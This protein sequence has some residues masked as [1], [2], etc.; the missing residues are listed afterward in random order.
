[1]PS[2]YPSGT[3]TFTTKQDQPGTV[4]GQ[5]YEIYAEDIDAIQDAVVAIQQNAVD[6]VNAQTV[7]GKK[8][9]S[10]DQ[11]FTSGRPWF[12]AVGLGVDPTGVVDAGAPLSS[13]LSA[14]AGVGPVYVPGG[15]YLITNPIYVPSN[16][17]IIL[18]RHA[19]LRQNS[20]SFVMT[21]AGR[22]S[23]FGVPN[24]NI[25]VLGGQFQYAVSG[26]TD[27]VHM[28][29]SSVTNLL[30]RDVTLTGSSG[31]STMALLLIDCNRVTIDGVY[32]DVYGTAP[33]SNNGLWCSGGNEGVISNCTILAGDDALAFSTAPFCSATT[34]LFNWTATNCYLKSRRG[35]MVDIGSTPS[36]TNNVYN[37]V[38]SN[39]VG[40]ADT[41]TNAHCIA[42]ENYSTAGATV[43]DIVISDIT[44][45][46]RGALNGVVAIG[47]SNVTFSNIHLLG[48]L[49]AGAT[50]AQ[51]LFAA[52]TA[53]GSGSPATDNV[54]FDRCSGSSNSA[55]YGL[56]TV[57]PGQ[58]SSA[59]N[60]CS[61]I[62]FDRC[63]ASGAAV[64]F[65]ILAYSYYGSI[66]GCSWTDCT[67]TN[68]GAAGYGVWV[69]GPSANTDNRVLNNRLTGFGYGLREDSGGADHNLY[70]G[71]NVRGCSIPAFAAPGGSHSVFRGNV[72][73]NPY[74]ALPASAGAIN[75]PAVPASGA[76]AVTNATGLDCMVVVNRAATTGPTVS[77]GGTSTGITLSATIPSFSFRVPAGQTIG[78]GTYTGTAP[79][80]TW[81]AD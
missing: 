15:T 34:D 5:P 41:A 51:C 66:V 18:D 30:L 78:L 56:L 58:L 64:G 31:G 54:H 13:I 48:P 7:G 19:V 52:L 10:G 29:W 21:N 4:L 81:V 46:A 23:G 69:P 50:T 6:K 1:M 17:T 26:G 44:C 37:V 35:R 16:S 9:Y 25:T 8:S 71:N 73:L 57:A 59:G 32:I 38:V 36:G 42:V 68:T 72:G 3:D 28:E 47:V 55:N 45:D 67:L 75:A 70:L 2:N 76:A 77:I 40:V 22:A 63:V 62:T 27:S 65:G 39:C 11:Y 60:G 79:T 80:W 14:A 12:D 49:A 61:N 24:S 20:T 33:A 53:A 43:H 74:G